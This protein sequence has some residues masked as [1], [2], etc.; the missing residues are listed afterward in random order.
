LTWCAIL[1]VAFIAL[2][3]IFFGIDRIGK[4]KKIGGKELCDV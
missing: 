2:G 1:F 3:F 4:A